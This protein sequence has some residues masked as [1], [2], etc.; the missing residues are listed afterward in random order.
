MEDNGAAT[1]SVPKVVLELAQG[2]LVAGLLY[3]L[4]FFSILRLT[5]FHDALTLSFNF[6]V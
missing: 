6:S 3:R 2:F 4:P 1:Y 5:L